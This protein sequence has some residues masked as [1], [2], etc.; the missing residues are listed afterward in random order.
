MSFWSRWIHLIPL[1][2]LQTVCLFPVTGYI[3]FLNSVFS[4]YGESDHLLSEPF[5]HLHLG[6]APLRAAPA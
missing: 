6:I 2:R 1:Q 4:S 5:D 3:C